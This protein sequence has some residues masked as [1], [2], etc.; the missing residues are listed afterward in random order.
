MGRFDKQEK[1]NIYKAKLN[2]VLACKPSEGSEINSK[3]LPNAKVDTVS[4]KDKKTFPSMGPDKY[5]EEKQELIRLESEPMSP[6]VIVANTPDPSKYLKSM[7]D[8]LDNI[9]NDNI[10]LQKVGDYFHALDNNLKP[11]KESEEAFNIRKERYLGFACDKSSWKGPPVDFNNPK[12]VQLTAQ[13]DLEGSKI[14]VEGVKNYLEGFKQAGYN[15]DTDKD[16]SQFIKLHDQISAEHNR[17]YEQFYENE[18]IKKKAFR[19]TWSKEQLDY[20][21]KYYKEIREEELKKSE[22]IRSEDEKRS[23]GNP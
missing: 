20:V 9:K 2:N 17:K 22:D 13:E 5:I 4:D 19:D 16:K 11:T 15:P 14:L 10:I 8:G 12:N 3:N 23:K 21:I 1:T 7:K 6:S 18:A